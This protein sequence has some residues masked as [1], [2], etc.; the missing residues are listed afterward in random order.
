MTAGSGGIAIFDRDPATGDLTQKQGRAGC[1]A[2]Y[3][4]SCAGGGPMGGAVAVALSP[5]GKSAYVSSHFGRAVVI[6]DRD[7]STGALTQKPDTEGCISEG[8]LGGACSDG[9]AIQSLAGLTVTGDGKSLYVSGAAGLAIFDRD[10]TGTLT[11]KSA[12]AGCV[13]EDGSGGVCL[14]G[15][16]VGASTSVTVSPDSKSLYL[17]GNPGLAIFDRGTTGALHQ[18]PG[19]AGCISHPRH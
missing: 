10:A 19:K 6:F 14:D 3:D 5:D 16:N 4:D 8:G 18:K 1:V 12:P 9:E 11:Q 7:L 17:G 15:A 2:Q 13:S